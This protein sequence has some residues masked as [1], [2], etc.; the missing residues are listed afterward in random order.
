MVFLQRISII[1]RGSPPYPSIRE[2]RAHSIMRKRNVVL[3]C[4]LL[5]MGMAVTGCASP[6]AD[7]SVEVD[8]HRLVDLQL[9]SGLLW[10]ETNVGAETPTDYGLHFAW[11]ETKAKAD[12]SQ[13]TY[14][15]GTAFEKMTR[16]NAADTLTVLL[17]EDDAATAAWGKAFRIPTSQEMEELG[18]TANCV[19]TWVEKA[20]P[21]GDKVHGY[22]V[23]SKRNGRTLFL[24]ASGAQNGKN[25]FLDGSDAVYWSAT[26]STRSYGEA[27]CLYFNLG[28]YSLYMN[29]RS[30]GASVRP[31]MERK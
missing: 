11:G 1:K 25:C 7:G 15:Y 6:S 17:P 26:L 4:I 10:A 2:E 27:F 22:E 30:I 14:R 13:A 8:G 3:S 19:W 5:A 21:K 9:P 29:D 28:H 20:S 16:Y 24:P 12:F 23:K 18:D 31:V